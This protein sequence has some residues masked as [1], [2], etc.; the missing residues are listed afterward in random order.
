MGKW[1]LR[2]GLIVVASWSLS[3]LPSP[4]LDKLFN[5][6]FLTTIYT[7]IGIMFPLGLN[8]IM[9]FSFADV[10]RDA[11]VNRYRGDLDIIRSIFVYLFIV[12]TAVFSFKFLDCIVQWKWIKFDI[13]CLYFVFLIFSLVYYVVNFIS[14]AKLKNE[15]EDKIREAKK[16]NSLQEE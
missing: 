8:Q 1:F 2:A 14:L 9:S 16:N 6:D 10:E 3:Y 12:S 7:V 5:K 11:F 15:I 13:R 4:F